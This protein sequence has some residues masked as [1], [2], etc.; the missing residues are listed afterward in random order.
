MRIDNCDDILQQRVGIYF[1]EVFRSVK[2][3]GC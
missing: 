3:D 2:T 1:F